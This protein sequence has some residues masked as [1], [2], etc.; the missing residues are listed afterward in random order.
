M[1]YTLK[2]ATHNFPCPVCP[3][4][5]RKGDIHVQDADGFD[6]CLCQLP[7]RRLIMKVEYE[8]RLLVVSDSFQ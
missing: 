4:K 2:I 7:S 5:V 8:R 6:F 1:A 3:V